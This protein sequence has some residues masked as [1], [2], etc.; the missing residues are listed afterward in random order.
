MKG[1]S[2]GTSRGRRKQ[3]HMPTAS[4][5]DGKDLEREPEQK[6]EAK[7]QSRQQT[8]RKLT[9]ANPVKRSIPLHILN[10]DQLEHP[11]PVP[12]LKELYGP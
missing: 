6:G 8:T 2:S 12:L 4:G 3:L 5:G 9:I 1:S 7:V 10:L 11:L